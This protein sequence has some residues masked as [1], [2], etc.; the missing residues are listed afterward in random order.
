[1]QR[2]LNTHSYIC[3]PPESSVIP[4]LFHK[5]HTKKWNENATK[6]F[7]SDVFLDEK[8]SNW[9]KINKGEF[10]NFVFQ[11][12][13]KNYKEAI[14]LLYR[15]YSKV[16]NNGDIIGDKN[17]ANSLY[18]KQILTLFPDAKFIVMVRNPIDNVYSFK[19]VDFDSNNTKVLAHRWNFYNNEI[20]KWRKKYPSQFHVIKFENLVSNIDETLLEIAKFIDVEPNFNLDG[21]EGGDFKWQKNLGK[22]ISKEH[23][24]KGEKNLPELD[25][26]AVIQISGNTANQLGYSINGKKANV[27][28]LKSW[29][30]N[31]I[32]KHFIRLPLYLSAFILKYYRRKKK[33]IVEN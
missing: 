3:I 30:F 16:N 23:I 1:M 25:K 29:F 5:Y 15:F 9:W 27:F 17:P 19:N 20:L 11:H 28:H 33:I 22:T 4:L 18:I 12:Y 31:Q 13:P 14:L 26:N 21:I 7:I 32:E 8:I 24:N 6:Q 2:L 10:K